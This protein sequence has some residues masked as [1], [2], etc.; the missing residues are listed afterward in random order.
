MQAVLLLHQT[1]KGIQNFNVH[2]TFCGS[3]AAGKYLQLFL[4]AFVQISGKHLDKRVDLPGK[5][6]LHVVEKIE[7]EHIGRP[8]IQFLQNNTDLIGDSIIR[9]AFPHPRIHA[10]SHELPFQ[11]SGSAQ[12][13]FWWCDRT[14][15]HL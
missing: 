10:K 5:C 14:G 8:R 11:Y 4:G 12:E 7:R 3:S 2:G 15:D 1:F 6:T 9:N 13:D